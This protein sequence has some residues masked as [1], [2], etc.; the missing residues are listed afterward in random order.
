MMAGA[1]ILL[2]GILAFLLLSDPN[3][4]G[5][6]IPATRF[7]GAIR[8]EAP[9]VRFSLRNQDGQLINASAL[10]GQPAIV[11]FMYSTCE[12]ACS[13]MA[14]QIRGA[15]DRLGRNVR[16]VAISVD[17]AEDTPE[18]AQAFIAEQR[19]DGRLDFLLGS[20]QTLQPVWRNFGVQ[21][22]AKDEEHSAVVVLLDAD[23]RQRISFPLSELTPEGI[24][25]DIRALQREAAS[26]AITQ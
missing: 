11:A 23:G 4:G 10:R 25:A 15:L 18:S 5:S 7:A 8:P 24:A 14:Q 13:T 3:A 6:R 17:P 2:L 26:Q 12:D 1:T 16:V 20:E 9:P 22:E 21:P 19:L